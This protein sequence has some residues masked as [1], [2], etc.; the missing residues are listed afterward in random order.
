MRL[1]AAG[2]S[3]AL[4][5]LAGCAKQLGQ[6]RGTTHRP[7]PEMPLTPRGEWYFQS[8]VGAYEADLERYRL[9]I[10]GLV[11]RELSLSVPV[12]RETFP[13]ASELI[14]LSCV[15]NVPNGSLMSS[16][17]LRGA[18]VRD[19]MEH[20]GVSPDASGA[21]ITGLD[22]FVA[23]Q[24]ID[25][26]RRSESIFAVDLG[27]DEDD[28]APLPIDHGFPCRI[29]TP[30]LYGYM[31]PKWID[32]VH[33]VDHGGYQS[34]ISKS[35]PYFEGKIQLAS[36]FS[37]PRRGGRLEPGPTEILGFA[38]GDGRPIDRVQ[39]SIDDGGWRDAEIVWNEIGDGLPSYLW[40]LWRYLWDAVPGEHAVKCRAFHSDGTTQFEGQRF[41]Y[42]GGSI[43][44]IRL[45]VEA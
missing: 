14:T 38:F 10:D 12:L 8:L 17:L 19:V 41:P 23:Y 7:T 45:E 28:L 35:I 21:L 2:L 39:V 43:A 31:Q 3:S 40:V 25:D 29:M 5:P 44:R 1:A 6:N 34:V 32:T 42:S 18:R 13:L 15:G 37:Q 27:V 20:A 24:T 22:G 26:L 33:F 36:G 30:G 16:G 9:K 11:D 4:W